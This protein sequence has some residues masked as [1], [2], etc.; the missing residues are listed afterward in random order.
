VQG[1]PDGGLCA[2]QDETPQLLDDVPEDE[3]FERISTGTREFD[4]VLGGGLVIGSA[5]LISGD[6]GIGKST[7]LTQTAI[8]FTFA[9]VIEADGG[10]ADPFKCLYVHPEETKTQVKLR[11]K[12]LSLSSKAL[13]LYH[14]MSVLEVDK[15][16][17]SLKPDVVYIDSIQMM[18]HPNYDAPPGSVTQVNACTDYLVG[19]C[20]ARAESGQP[21]AL[22]IVAHITKEG[23]IAGPK[24]LEHKVDVVLEFGKEGASNLRSIRASKNRFGDTTEMALFEMTAT[25]LRSIENPSELLLEHH[26]DDMPGSCIGIAAHGS[27]PMAVEVQTLLTGTEMEEGDE[28]DRETGLPMKIVKRQKARKRH[29]T[30]L[31]PKRVNQVIAVLQKRAGDRVE[32]FDP[33]ETIVSIA[34][35]I[36]MRDSGLDLPLALALASSLLNKCLPKKFMAFGEVGL[37]GEIRPVSYAEARMKTG[38]RLLHFEHVV[39]PVLPEKDIA[40]VDLGDALANSEPPEDET[41]PGTYYGVKTLE[42]AIEIALF[43]DLSAPAPS[44]RPKRL[45]RSAA[46]ATIPSAPPSSASRAS[47]APPSPPI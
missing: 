9:D 37:L 15:H 41:P 39:G 23:N 5:V 35:G 45:S 1:K 40:T 3:S 16:I 47:T 43:G 25:G 36:E 29:V 6:P 18:V 10:K 13:W 27:R 42:E 2:I 33:T 11:A 38:T 12:R 8:D 19:T 21:Y 30:G 17:E 26:R 22:I 32:H 44:R 46:S 14:Q 31:D 4:R 24:A 28:E 7:L 34:G 20:K